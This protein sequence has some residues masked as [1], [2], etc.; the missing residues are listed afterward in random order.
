MGLLIHHTRICESSLFSDQDLNTICQPRGALW[1][2]LSLFLTRT[3]FLVF[4]RFSEFVVNLTFCGISDLCCLFPCLLVRRLSRVLPVLSRKATI[5][6]ICENYGSPEGQTF[7]LVGKK[8][9]ATI[10]FNVFF[11]PK[12][13]SLNFIHGKMMS[14]M[15]TFF[16]QDFLFSFFYLRK[17]FF[18]ICETD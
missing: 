6:V 17:F 12:M 18:F 1:S 16:F 7:M 2:L 14:C 3:H 15:K 13:K 9:F 8:S 4:L 5:Q 10:I 11:I